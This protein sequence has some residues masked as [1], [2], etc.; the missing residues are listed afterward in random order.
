MGKLMGSPAWAQALNKFAET[1]PR[2]AFVIG[3]P[4]GLSER[5]LKAS[6]LQLALSPMTFTHE[7]ARILLLEQLYRA[8]TILK[9]EKYHK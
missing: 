4:F 5:I 1:Y 8:F 9:G 7:L 6:R 3:G 2:T